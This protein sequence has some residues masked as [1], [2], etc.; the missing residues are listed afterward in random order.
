MKCRPSHGDRGDDRHQH[1]SQVY[2]SGRHKR[3]GGGAGRDYPHE[4]VSTPYGDRRSREAPRG[5]MRSRREGE[6]REQYSQSDREPKRRRSDP[7][8]HDYMN[9]HHDE[10]DAR[11]S[12]YVCVLTQEGHLSLRIDHG[13]IKKHSLAGLDFHVSICESGRDTAEFF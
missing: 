6:G 9:G 8:G 4:Q 11:G 13:L 7:M 10:R 2:D 12:G 5:H 3:A 1:G